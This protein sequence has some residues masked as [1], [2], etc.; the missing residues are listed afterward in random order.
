MDKAADFRKRRNCDLLGPF[1]WAPRSTSA[2]P[3]V[4][5]RECSS[6]GFD[7]GCLLEALNPGAPSEGSCR[8]ELPRAVRWPTIDLRQLE[9]FVRIARLGGFR[10]AAEDLA[11]SQAALSQ[12]M[13]LLEAELRAP[14]FERAHRPVDLTEADR[15]APQSRAWTCRS[16]HQ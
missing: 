13:K 12:Q 4:R 14:L 1:L 10:R 15:T 6:P 9:N 2:C 8:P 16:D 5:I 3:C 11:V 7:E